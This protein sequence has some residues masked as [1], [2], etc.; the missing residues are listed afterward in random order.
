MLT[1]PRDVHKYPGTNKLV[2]IDLNFGHILEKQFLILKEAAIN[3]EIPK[4][5]FNEKGN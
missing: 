4:N 2:D 1:S 3:V 5:S